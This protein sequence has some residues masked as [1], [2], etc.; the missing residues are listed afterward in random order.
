MNVTGHAI[1]SISA[2]RFGEVGEDHMFDVIRER[3]K[4]GA[5]TEHSGRLCIEI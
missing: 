4:G 1:K 2:E 5:G 3:V